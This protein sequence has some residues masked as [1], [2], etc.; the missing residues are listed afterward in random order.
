MTSS[1][2]SSIRTPAGLLGGS[3]LHPRCGPG[4]I[5]IGYW[6]DG[7]KTG[8]GIATEASAALTRVGMEVM[9]AR[10]TEIH[11]APDNAASAAIPRRLGYSFEGRLRQR[12]PR[13]DGTLR[14]TS[15]FCLLASEYADSVSR[16][17]PVAAFDALNGPL[18]G[19][20][21]ADA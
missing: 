11:C 13:H 21:Q 19:E 8:R 18:L 5:E 14:D 3:G 16:G 17:A 15:V 12:E 20:A 2:A 7:E 10:R 1:T 4:G 6:T 9:G